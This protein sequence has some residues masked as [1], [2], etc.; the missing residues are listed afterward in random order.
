MSTAP[1]LPPIAQAQPAD[2]KRLLCRSHPARCGP[3]SAYPRQHTHW[4]P[5][6]INP[7]EDSDQ[8]A[9]GV[10]TLDSYIEFKGL[11]HATHLETASRII[12]DRRIEGRIA[13]DS[14]V[15]N[16]RLDLLDNTTIPLEYVCVHHTT[17]GWVAPDC[18]LSE[19]F[20]PITFNLSIYG[21]EGIVSPG[22]GTELNFFT[23]YFLEVIDYHSSEAAS[24]ILVVPSSMAG[25]YQ[26]LDHLRYDPALRGGPWYWDQANNKHYAL[27][28][29]IS[30][31]GSERN[32]T[33]E[34]IRYGNFDFPHHISSW[35]VVNHLDC[36]RYRSNC[37]EVQITATEAFLGMWALLVRL[38]QR[39]RPE[40]R[41]RN[42]QRPGVA[43]QQTL[44]AQPRNLEA[45]PASQELNWEVFL[46]CLRDRNFACAYAVARKI[47]NE[48][49]NA[50]LPP[51]CRLVNA[52]DEDDDEDDDDDS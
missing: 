49:M 38:S 13:T 15:A 11:V 47:P 16:P 45:D 36:K 2:G 3:R 19:R 42:D 34:F 50:R 7:L 23:Y 18:A 20:G 21:S 32:H 4:L 43:F 33:L 52:E 8:T 31:K 51:E 26:A 37:L 40:Y 41:E 25:Q 44:N 24:R 12:V 22:T 39:N 30:Y 9:L 46:S 17:T 1:P 27:R 6:T 14:T 5:D 35:S 48:T 28:R 29:S 10:T